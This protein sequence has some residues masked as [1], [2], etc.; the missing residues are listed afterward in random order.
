M[1]GGWD[2]TAWELMGKPWVHL[3][4]LG[5]H[6]TIAIL[7]PAV[8][9]IPSDFLPPLTPHGDITSCGAQVPGISPA[10]D[11]TIVPICIRSSPV[12]SLPSVLLTPSAFFTL[13]L[14]SNGPKHP[15]PVGSTHE[16]K[17]KTKP[18]TTPRP[19]FEFHQR[20][21]VRSLGHHGIS[22]GL[23]FLSWETEPEPM[24]KVY[25]DQTRSW[26][27]SCS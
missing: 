25:K 13:H 7:P 2:G 6:D 20:G 17:N 11:E 9:P 21:A 8:L 14:W 12:L 3:C 27:W 26:V 19:G 1:A 15:S 22:L 24:S 23:G 18:K 5:F 10:W 4:H 16:D